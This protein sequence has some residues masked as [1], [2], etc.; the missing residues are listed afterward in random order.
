MRDRDVRSAVRQMLRTRYASDPDTKIVEEM[1]IWSGSVRI[2]LAVINGELNGYELK[3]DRD[4][5][6][7]LPLQAELYSRVFDR[8]TL[9]VG[10]RH[11]AKAS[12]QVPKW[13]GLWIAEQNGIR[14]TLRPERES[15]RNPNPDSYL[16]AQLL[17]KEE[18]IAVLDEFNLAIGWRNRRVKEI[19]Q[20]LASELSF[21]RLTERVRATL[22]GRDGWLRQTRPHQFNMPVHPNPYPMFEIFGVLTGSDSVDLPIRPTIR[23]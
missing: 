4:T 21:D 6:E 19:H 18:A 23:K 13:W 7:R 3:S 8:L 9:V 16:I 2:D 17:W 22:K 12:K 20:R 11:V 10:K 1:G 14:V 5:L 15:K